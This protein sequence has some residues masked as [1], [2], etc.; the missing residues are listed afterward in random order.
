MYLLLV[1][2]CLTIG[3]QAIT[4]TDT[5]FHRN[6]HEEF[7][8]GA[9]VSFVPMMESWGTKWLDKNGRQK[10]ILQIL[11]EQGINNI[12]LRVWTVASGASSK[13]EV[14]AMC[15][16]A[17]AK[18]MG[19]KNIDNTIFRKLLSVPEYKDRYLRIYGN[20]FKTF[21]TN[22]M[23]SLLNELVDLIQPEMQLHWARWGEEN[24]RMVISEVPVTVDGAYRYWEKRVERLRNVC[25]WRPSRLWDFTQDAF[26]LTTPEMEKYFGKKPEVPPDAT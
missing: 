2:A 17:K 8:F 21:T 5:I 11:K 10:D 15:K 20:I 16:R 25:R 1:M 7:A 23:I 12:R 13:D 6:D 14:V 9:D 3:A 19:E 22:Y 24:D 18:G 26:N 4:V